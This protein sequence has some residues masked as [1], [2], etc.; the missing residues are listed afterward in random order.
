VARAMLR[1]VVPV[2]PRVLRLGP[3]VRGGWE[4]V[5][6]TPPMGEGP[7]VWSPATL[8]RAMQDISFS[9]SLGPNH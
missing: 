1:N 2:G 4:A 5:R 9:F 8:H 7:Y 6:V 3:A